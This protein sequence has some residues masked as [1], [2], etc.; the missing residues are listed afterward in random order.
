[1]L[2]S[3]HVLAVKRVL[4]VFVFIPSVT[5]IGSLQWAHTKSEIIL[6]LSPRIHVTKFQASALILLKITNDLPTATLPTSSW[7]G[8]SCLALFRT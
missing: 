5:G 2:G 6:L 3:M 1:M 7:L 4:N 8:T